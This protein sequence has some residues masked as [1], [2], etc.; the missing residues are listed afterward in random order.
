MINDS[1]YLKRDLWLS[2]E[3][4]LSLA[5]DL[6]LDNQALR[7]CMALLTQLGDFVANVFA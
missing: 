2:T 4:W 6:C 7:W 5:S 3:I 1:K